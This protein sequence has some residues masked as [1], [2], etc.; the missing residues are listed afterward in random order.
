MNSYVINTSKAYR[1]SRKTASGV[2]PMQ[3]FSENHAIANNVS[4]QRC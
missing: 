2:E 4:P 3:K 1:K